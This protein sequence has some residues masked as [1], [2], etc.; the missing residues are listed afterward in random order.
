MSIDYQTLR[1]VE[2]NDMWGIEFK[3]SSGETMRYTTQ[4]PTSQVSDTCMAEI[5]NSIEHGFPVEN[6]RELTRVS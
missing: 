2:I 5:L 6:I 4:K 1:T 3:T